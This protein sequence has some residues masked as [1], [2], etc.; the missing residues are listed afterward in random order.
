[1]VQRRGVLDGGHVDAGD[2]DLAGDG[3]TEVDDV[4][5][6]GLLLVGKL[7]G[8]G[9]H[10][11]D[12]LFRNLLALIGRLDAEQL[13]ETVGRGRGQP[14]E[15]R[16]QV[17]ERANGAGHRL[18]HGL[19]VGKRDALR[20]QLTDDGREVGDD[21]GD[22]HDGDV[23]GDAGGHTE[24]GEPLGQR[25]REA[26]RREG[27]RREPDECDR[28]LNRGEELTGVGRKV[29]RALR[30]LIPVLGLRLEN[31]SLRIDDGHLRGGEEAVCEGE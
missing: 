13:G 15:R 16:C 19:G 29:N 27:G 14:N 20:H 26:R 7:L 4:V 28:H 21:E 18:C 8:V 3:I 31:G 10:V 9:N 24:G 5:D 30:A 22:R 11:L 12:L 17:H 25:V 1:M 6:H 2:H 23:A